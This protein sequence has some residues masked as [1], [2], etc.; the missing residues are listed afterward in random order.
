M[1]NHLSESVCPT[2][3]SLLPSNQAVEATNT[4]P[5]KDWES[6]NLHIQQLNQI[7]KSN[8]KWFKTNFDLDELFIEVCLTETNILP[9]EF[10]KKVFTWCGSGTMVLVHY[11]S[12]GTAGL[13][14]YETVNDFISDTKDLK[15][16]L[17]FLKSVN[18]EFRARVISQ[19]L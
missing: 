14:S 2:I 4:Q 8:Q 11:V 17:S 18:D 13:Q 16:C 1:G 10:R 19:R 3:A 7:I 15:D 9:E 6:L 5:L 12:V